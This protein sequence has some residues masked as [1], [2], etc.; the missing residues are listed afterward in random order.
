MNANH[1]A[2][3]DKDNWTQLA[4]KSIGLDPRYMSFVE[5]GLIWYD[6]VWYLSSSN[7]YMFSYTTCST[8]IL[9]SRDWTEGKQIFDFVINIM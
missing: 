3:Y 2:F 5:S 8:L 7:L 6:H 1:R 4:S 9:I